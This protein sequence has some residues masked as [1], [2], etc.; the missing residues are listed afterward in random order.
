MAYGEENGWMPQ[1][2]AEDTYRFEDVPQL[3]AD[4]AEGRVGYFPVYEV[5]P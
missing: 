5:N 3:L 2:A 1:V 4:Y